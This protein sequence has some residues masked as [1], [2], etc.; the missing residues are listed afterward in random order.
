ME[1]IARLRQVPDLVLRTTLITG[2]PGET[3]AEFQELYD[4]VEE[5]EFDRVGVFAY[6]KEEGTDAAEMDGQVD[7][8][9][10]EER[11]DALMELQQGISLTRNRR[12]IG[13][14]LQVLVDGVSEE[15]EYVVEG[16]YYGQAPEID[17]VVYLSYDDGGDPATPGTMVDVEIV[18]AT[19]YDLAGVVLAPNPLAIGEQGVSLAVGRPKA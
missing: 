17:G 2:F 7:E 14:T 19:P 13:R 12:L 5:V 1:L 11:R 10:K 8:E 3:D 18:D 15:H 4:W 9:V 16:R 6:S